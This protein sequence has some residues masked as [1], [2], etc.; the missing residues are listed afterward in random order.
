[1]KM[2][3]KVTEAKGLTAVC[4]RDC[5]SW[6]EDEEYLSRF[7]KY[8]VIRLSLKTAKQPN[9]REV[10]MALQRIEEKRYTD[11]LH[12][13]RY[14]ELNRFVNIKAKIFLRNDLYNSKALQFELICFQNESIS[15]RIEL[16]RA[17]FIP[18]TGKKNGKCRDR[19]YGILSGK[20]A[21]TA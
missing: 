12:D 10:H 17:F 1:M 3:V 13:D 21:R 6:G 18:F 9:F 14:Q 4:L 8:P 5:V 20:R 19:C 11:E 7:G 2:S 16:G 15:T